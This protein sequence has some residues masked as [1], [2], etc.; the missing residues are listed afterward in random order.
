MRGAWGGLARG[1]LA[2][3]PDG[4]G[5]MVSSWVEIFIGNL[6]PRLKTIALLRFRGSK[7]VQGAGPGVTWLTGG[8]RPWVGHAKR[9]GTLKKGVGV[10]QPGPEDRLEARATSGARVKPRYIWELQFSLLT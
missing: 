1:F 6:I 5:V 8:S 4:M 9:R 2:R 10:G 3:E 7:A